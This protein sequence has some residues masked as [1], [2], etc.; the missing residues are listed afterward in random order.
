MTTTHNLIARRAGHDFEIFEVTPH[1]ESLIGRLANCDNGCFVFLAETE[2]LQRHFD[3]VDSPDLSVESQLPAIRLAFETR[4]E[5]EVLE[6]IEEARA[7]AMT[8]E[9]SLAWSMAHE[10]NDAHRD[11]MEREASWH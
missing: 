7:E 4:R 10:S 2:E 6:G 3:A 8:D 5:E 11:E 9:G 1:F